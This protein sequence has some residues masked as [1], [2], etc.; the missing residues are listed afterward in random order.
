VLVVDNSPTEENAD[1]MRAAGCPVIWDREIAADTHAML[2]ITHSMEIIRQRFL[3]GDWKWWFNL[4]ADIIPPINVLEM[5]LHWGRES[6]WISHAYPMRGG[7]Q[8][9]DEQ[10]IGCSILSRRLIQ[11]FRFGSI[12]DNSPDGGLWQM[13]RPARKYRTM[14]MWGYFQVDHLQ[15]PE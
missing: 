11:D 4:E 9:D 13:V 1:K 8:T 14:E 7:N 12:G 6:D 10:G 2:R 3:A 5:M 15:A